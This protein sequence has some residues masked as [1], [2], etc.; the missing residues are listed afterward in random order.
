MSRRQLLFSI[1]ATAVSVIMLL[2]AT[3]AWLGKLAISEQLAF[4]L[5]GLGVGIFVAALSFGYGPSDGSHRK[6]FQARA[7]APQMES[8]FTNLDN[9]DPDD[10][11]SDDEDSD[12][13]ASDKSAKKEEQLPSL[14]GLRLSWAKDGNRFIVEI[15][16]FPAIIGCDGS[17][18]I[19]IQ[20]ESVRPRH[21]EIVYDANEYTIT[22]LDSGGETSVNGINISGRTLLTPDSSVTVG[23]VQISTAQI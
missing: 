9:D 4:V 3:L 19:V 17:C 21:A 20:D 10:D 5:T 23:S 12:N 7:Y 13:T 11:D 16:T 15:N 8:L 6:S 18:D 22:D 14:P 1:F 2:I